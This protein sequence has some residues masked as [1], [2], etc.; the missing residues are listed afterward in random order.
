MSDLIDNNTTQSVE[1]VEN[2][3]SPTPVESTVSHTPTNFHDLLSEDLRGVD[4]LKDFKDVNSLAKSYVNAQKMIGNS[5]RIPAED[6]PTE[7]KSDFIN[8]LKEIPGVVYLGEDTNSESLKDVYYKLGTPSE[9]S[10]YQVDSLPEGV[11]FGEGLD[12]LK[13]YAHN[14]KLTNEQFKGLVDFRV[15]ELQQ[16][17]QIH[18]EF[19]EKSIESAKAKWGNQFT[20]NVKAA[21]AA[22]NQYKS[23]FPE[24]VEQIYRNP[25]LRNNP[26]LVSVLADIGKAGIER[27]HI[28]GDTS[29]QF[30]KAP[31]E[32]KAEIS[33]LRA[34]KSDALYRK[35]HPE[36]QQVTKKLNELYDQLSASLEK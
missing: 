9:P 11:Q 14:L 28:K 36:H 23:E 13:N 29:I 8:K 3:A 6:A 35:N 20:N 2:N 15:K 22:L 5:I 25:L 21:E 24:A 12:D 1:S 32:L 30:G 19:I 27:G 26:V 7:A 16:E 31:Q 34:Y 17:S 18:G 33:E 4:S 10:K